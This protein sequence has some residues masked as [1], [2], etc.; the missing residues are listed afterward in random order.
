[1][2]V[3]GVVQRKDTGRPE[4][5][6][7]RNCPG[8]KIE[9]EVL[10]A[11]LELLLGFPIERG[12]KVNKAEPDGSVMIDGRTCLIEFDHSG[13]MNARQWQQKLNRYGKFAGFLLV[14]ATSEGRMKRLMKFTESVKD[15][16]LYTTMERLKGMKE[17]WLDGKGNAWGL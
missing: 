2:K 3:V 8:D 13:K 15:V 4:I 9:H 11:E 17:P 6:Y 12:V 1:M 5:A 7:G 14:V 10:F 16:T